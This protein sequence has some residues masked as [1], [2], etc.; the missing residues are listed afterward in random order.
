[1]PEDGA[2]RSYA[3]AFDKISGLHYN[4]SMGASPK[5]LSLPLNQPSRLRLL[6]M[7]EV[8]ERL[9]VSL[10]RAYEMGRTGLLPIVRLGRGGTTRHLGRRWGASASWRMAE[11][12]RLRRAR[13]ESKRTR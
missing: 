10:Q 12:A 11:T 9:G 2:L 13:C 4:T 3:A 1:M 5:L 8:A 7:Q 6:N